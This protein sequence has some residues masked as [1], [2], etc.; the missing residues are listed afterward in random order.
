MRRRGKDYKKGRKGQE[1]EYV[2]MQNQES[3][4]FSIH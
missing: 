3:L 4:L 1:A 2:N